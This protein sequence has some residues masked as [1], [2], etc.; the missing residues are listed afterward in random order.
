MAEQ[1]N[2]IRGAELSDDDLMRELEHLH[3]TRHDT[4]LN[5]SEHALEHHTQR[6]VELEGEY[7]RRFKHETPDDLRTRAGSRAVA[8]QD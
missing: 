4:F 5:G 6:M 1:Q 7:R 3:Q 8:G 2:G